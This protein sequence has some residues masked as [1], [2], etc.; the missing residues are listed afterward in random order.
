ML[1]VSKNL[2]SLEEFLA[3]ERAQ[4]ERYEYGGG[5][6][7]MMTGGSLDHSTIAPNLYAI[8]EQDERL[9]DLYT[10]T[11]DRWIDEIVEGDVV[12]KLSSIGVEIGLDTVYEDIDLDAIRRREGERQIPA[13]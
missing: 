1:N 3:W 6:I 13:E 5:V 11:G 12:L 8:I 2:M 10:R 9:I 7:T 4:P